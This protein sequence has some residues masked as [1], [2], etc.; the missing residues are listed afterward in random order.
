MSSECARSCACVLM[1]CSARVMVSSVSSEDPLLWLNTAC[2]SGKQK[3]NAGAD[4]ANA[5][6]PAMIER[7]AKLQKRFTV[8]LVHFHALKPVVIWFMSIFDPLLHVGVCYSP[9]LPSLWGAVF[10]CSSKMVRCVAVF[11]SS[12]AQAG[13]KSHS[14]FSW[15]KVTWPTRT[16]KYIEKNTDLSHVHTGNLLVARFIHQAFMTHIV[17]IMRCL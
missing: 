15:R 14:G 9:V 13:S 4:R 16:A 6:D 10:V 12:W 2:S 8:F 11:R 1:T 3:E 7:F 17:R 5:S